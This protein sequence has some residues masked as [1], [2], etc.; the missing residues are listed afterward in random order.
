[1]NGKIGALF[2]EV[3]TII[4]NPKEILELQNITSKIEKF[5]V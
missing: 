5:T 3:N 4:N 2:R 1:M